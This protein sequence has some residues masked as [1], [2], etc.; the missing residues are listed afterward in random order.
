MLDK[1]FM[2]KDEKCHGG[3]LSKE[4]VT[5]LVDANSY[6][7]EK[8]PLLMFGKSANPHCFKNVEKFQC[9]YKN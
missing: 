5:V 4:G 8:L 9:V 3:K 7:S 1:S 2:F 6:G